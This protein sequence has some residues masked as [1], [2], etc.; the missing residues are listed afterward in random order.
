MPEACG[1]LSEVQLI[2]SA[3]I[4]SFMGAV[5]WGLAMANYGN[6]HP[7]ISR[8]I[9]SVIPPIVSF[10]SALFTPTTVSLLIHAAG[11]IMLLAYDVHTTKLGMS[12][13]WYPGLRVVLTDG[14][15]DVYWYHGGRL[16]GQGEEVEG[17]FG[18]R[19]L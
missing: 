17:G 16:L 5:Q 6:S 11:F 7:N 10:M 3:C 19:C 15:C 9:F 4:L 14:C 12:P 8:Y 13:A 18:E 2:Y 1:L